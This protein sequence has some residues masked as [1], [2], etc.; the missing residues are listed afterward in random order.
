MSRSGDVTFLW[1][2]GEH[3]FR[4]GIKQLRELQE[5]CDAGPAHILARLR[6]GEWR[7]DDARETLRLGLIGAGLKA[8]EALKLVLRYV[9]DRPLMESVQPAMV[10]L[11]TALYGPADE[12]ID[13][14]GESA[15]GKP[16]AA[17]DSPSSPTESSPSPPS[18]APAPPSA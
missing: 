5:K 16:P 2:D 8:E 15:A 7:I 3:T 14:G 6:T 11:I 13:D 12:P 9:D 1:G 18:T 17:E 4:L 10:V